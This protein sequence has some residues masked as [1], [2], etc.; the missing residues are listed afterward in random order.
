[1]NTKSTGSNMSDSATDIKNRLA[2]IGMDDAKRSV[3][4]EMRPLIAK[5][6]PDVLDRFYVLIG[7]T[8][9]VG[10]MFSNPQHMR[11]ARDMQLKHWD[12]IA[13]ADFGDDYVT[14]VTRIGETHNRLG[15]EPRW[16][17]GGY[18]FILSG[19]IQAIETSG[20]LTLG[21]TKKARM[22]DAFISAALLDMDIAISVY[23]EA[24][25][26]EKEELT[27][28]VD[29][30]IDAF[31]VSSKEILAHVS[32]EAG[33]MRDSAQGM[34]GVA[35]NASQQSV[36]AAAAAEET[37]TNVQTVAAAAE[38]LGSSIQEIGRQ[39]EQATRA[40]RAAGSTTERSATEIEGLS[41]AGQRIGAVVDL[42]QAIAAQTNLLALNATIEAA[43]AGEAGRGFAVVASEVKNLAA[44]TAKATEEIA[45][46]VAG[47]QTS[48]K[49][50]VD[51]V[52]EIAAA[53]RQIDEVTTT[54]ASAVEEQGAATKEITQ[55]VHMA[56]TGTQ[57]LAS[58]ISTVNGAI[59]EAHRSAE[60][61]LAA[62]GNV[63]EQA[64]QMAQE[65][66]T[67]FLRLR[68]GPMDRRKADDPDY[69]GPERRV[70]AGVAAA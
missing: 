70:T 9:E 35:S 33:G 47:I 50:A 51:A 63:V 13:K 31:R 28:S 15:L 12:V 23:L 41:S 57:T 68:S 59:D 40:V 2:F 56:A 44:Q 38:E 36:S 52:K 60:Q 37:A 5:I 58:N 8:T 46:Q 1:M 42:I 32:R 4:R 43:R 69:K 20:G 17:I 61:V 54:I 62:S 14:S 39:V 34:T 3:L 55:N 49:S 25:R 27:R 26:R 19:I 16:Y 66:E 45:Q 24:G 10:R 30:A 6:L 65:V 67:F 21:K 48:T 64:S 7:K 22:M 29:A 18:N 53:M 11:H